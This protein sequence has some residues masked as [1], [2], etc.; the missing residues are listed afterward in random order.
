MNWINKI[1]FFLNSNS[2]KGNFNEHLCQ[3]LLKFLKLINVEH[4]IQYFMIFDMN[5][6]KNKEGLNNSL[7]ARQNTLRDLEK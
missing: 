2:I 7:L 4:F 5:L 3:N 6:L 1:I